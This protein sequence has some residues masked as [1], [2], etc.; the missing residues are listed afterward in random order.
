MGSTGVHGKKIGINFSKKL[1]GIHSVHID[2]KISALNVLVFKQSCIVI[3]ILAQC[4]DLLLHF[5]H[6]YR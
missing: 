4:T 3:F 2:I 5:S 1:Y 6:I